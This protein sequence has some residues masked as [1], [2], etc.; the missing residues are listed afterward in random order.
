MVLAA[1]AKP[2]SPA[3]LSIP[4]FKP[5]SPCG[6]QPVAISPSQRALRRKKSEAAVSSSWPPV[7]VTR[8]RQ[9]GCVLRLEY[10]G[11]ARGVRAL[12]GQRVADVEALPEQVDEDPQ[13]AVARALSRAPI[14]A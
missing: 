9:T 8:H 10:E 11:F 5:W 1:S 12:V 2:S 6:R 7:T 13:R 3:T 14:A 4:A